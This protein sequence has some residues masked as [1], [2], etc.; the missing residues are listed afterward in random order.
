MKPL[1]PY[2]LG[3][4]NFPE[5]NTRG[6]YFLHETNTFSE[7]TRAELEKQ[8]YCNLNMNIYKI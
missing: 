8:P 3:S 4:L 5:K 1:I 6:R 7:K 2:D